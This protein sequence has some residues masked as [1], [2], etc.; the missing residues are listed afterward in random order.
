MSLLPIPRGVYPSITD[1]DPKAL[2]GKGDGLG[3]TE[4]GE[5][6]LYSGETLLSAVPVA[7][8]GGTS[9]HRVL[10]HRDA[11]DQHPIEAISGLEEISNRRV[12]E[13]WN[14]GMSL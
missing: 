11:E 10:S 4:E 5:L 1:I 13:I 3:Y 6:G 14:G 8:G 7:G 12:L 2:A 9:D